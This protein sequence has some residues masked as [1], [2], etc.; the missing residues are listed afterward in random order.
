MREL[1]GPP[2]QSGQPGENA[3]TGNAKSEWTRQTISLALVGHEVD[4][5]RD[6]REGHMDHPDTTADN[7]IRAHDLDR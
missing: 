7:F 3:A 6:P 2:T 1:S 5:G 4:T